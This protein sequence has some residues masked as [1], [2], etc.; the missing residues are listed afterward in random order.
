MKGEQGGSMGGRAEWSNA[1]RKRQARRRRAEEREWASRS[2]A[3]TI[4]QV[5]DRAWAEARELAKDPVA[6]AQ[7]FRRECTSC[8]SRQLG[9]SRTEDGGARWECR[10]CG[11]WGVFGAP[12]LESGLERPSAGP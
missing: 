3:V 2:G 9:W 7:L 6:F 5:G 8:P 12:E 11:E 1:R 10:Q 4:R